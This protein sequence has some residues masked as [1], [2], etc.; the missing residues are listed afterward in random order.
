MNT[1][2]ILRQYADDIETTADM[3]HEDNIEFSDGPDKSRKTNLIQTYRWWSGSL[4]QAAW[5]LENVLSEN[6]KRFM[7]FGIE[8][9]TGLKDIDGDKLYFEDIVEL[10][11]PGEGSK[12]LKLCYQIKFIQNNYYS[13]IVKVSGSH[14]TDIGHETAAKLK[15][16]GPGKDHPMILK[17]ITT[18]KEG[19]NANREA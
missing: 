7:G 12:D 13:K 16:I 17:S 1:M 5:L 10:P 8:N 4:R 18:E 15:R 11:A 9:W 2:E 3:I 6:A 19:Q 14:H